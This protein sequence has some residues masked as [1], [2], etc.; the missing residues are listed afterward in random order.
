MDVSSLHGFLFTNKRTH[1][2]FRI[3]RD[4]ASHIAVYMYHSEISI[5]HDPGW[6]P[7]PRP[8]LTTPSWV[9]DG[10]SVANHLKVLCKVFALNFL[11]NKR[12]SAHFLHSF[13]KI[14]RPGLV[15]V[16]K[17]NR[18]K[19]G[20]GQTEGA[21]EIFYRPLSQLC[22]RNPVRDPIGL[23]NNYFGSGTSSWESYS[24][25]ERNTIL[26]NHNFW[27]QLN[28][29]WISQV[30]CRSGSQYS[31]SSLFSGS[32]LRKSHWTLWRISWHACR[33]DLMGWRGIC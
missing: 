15:K 8:V 9:A 14:S 21:T 25:G 26:I 27:K 5:L 1:F 3:A 19:L 7:G 6:V 20:K 11:K 29:S 17:L 10:R 28:R 4:G 24:T 16:T 18:P 22:R 13:R 33:F 23:V 12:I 30:G 32:Q 31:T 2:L